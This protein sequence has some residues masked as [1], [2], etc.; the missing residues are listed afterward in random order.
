MKILI[1][2]S[3]SFVGKELIQQCKKENIEIIGIDVIP[4]QNSDYEYH[5][6][7]I[8]SPKI[9]QYIPDNIDIVVHLAALS[10]YTI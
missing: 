3:E 9:I 10:K 4:K 1:T 8:K 7:D 6:I 5:Q 2:G